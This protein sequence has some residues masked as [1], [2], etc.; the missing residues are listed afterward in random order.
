[1]ETLDN[2][3]LALFHVIWY[4]GWWPEHSVSAMGGIHPKGIVQCGG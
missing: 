4:G 3:H 1:L 2:L